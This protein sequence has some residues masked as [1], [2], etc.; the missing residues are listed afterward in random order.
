M[1]RIFL[2]LALLLLPA[3]VLARDIV[4]FAAASLKNAL[5][6]AAAQY[7]AATGTGVALSYAGS[8]ALARQIEQGAPADLFVS[9]NA[10]WV[11]AL[12]A[13]GLILSDTRFALA[14]NRLVLAGRGA[15]DPDIAAWLAQVG[16]DTRLA[17]ALVDAVPAGIYGKAA[18]THLGLWDSAAPH[19]VQT[20]NVR[21]ALRL[22]TLGEAHL[23]IV[24]DTDA[25][26]EAGIAALAIFP[27]A[28]HP[29]IRY[30]AA[31]VAGRT[32]PETA[33]F[34]AF[35]Q[36]DAARAILARHGFLTGVAE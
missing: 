13:Q 25:R 34:R 18:L 29:P 26:L 2:T 6:E 19:V 5:D 33:A 14:G 30:V 20:D 4:V 11:D 36:G 15:P 10:L 3:S 21:A 28:S 24:Y 17:M 1:T 35:L 23:G 31:E 7:E 8:S 12:A 16:P 32:H 9:A 22:V 27:E